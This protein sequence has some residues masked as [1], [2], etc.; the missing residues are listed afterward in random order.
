MCSNNLSCK[1]T[2]D[3]PWPFLLLSVLAVTSSIRLAIELQRAT[4][5]PMWSAYRTPLLQMHV[6]SLRL[7]PPELLNSSKNFRRLYLVKRS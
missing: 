6:K 1:S 7:R 4:W 5:R 3:W 2:L